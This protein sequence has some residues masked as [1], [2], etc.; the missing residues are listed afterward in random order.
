MSGPDQC[1]RND[2]GR[3]MPCAKRSRIGPSEFAYKNAVHCAYCDA[4]LRLVEPVK[5]GK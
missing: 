5:K 3:V 4:F 1:T 2:A